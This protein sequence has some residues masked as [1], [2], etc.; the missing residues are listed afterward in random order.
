MKLNY[1]PV[2]DTAEYKAVI[3]AVKEQIEAE[4]REMFG[5]WPIR[6]GCHAAWSLQKK[7]LKEHGIDWH[8]PSEMNPRVMFD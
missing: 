2:E 3:R 4:M 5:V 8:S 6:G 1:D 7:L